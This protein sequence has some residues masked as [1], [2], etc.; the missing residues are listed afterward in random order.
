M[1]FTSS[2]T[3]TKQKKSSLNTP[4][5]AALKEGPVDW[6]PHDYQKKAMKFA[7]ERAVAALFLDPGLGKTSITLGVFK[8][9]KARKIIRR[10]LVIC[11]LRVAHAVWPGEVKKWKNFNG[12]SLSILHGKDKDRLR[13]DDADIHVIN[14]EGLEWLL[15]KHTKRSWPY[16]M[17]VVD[18]STFFKHTNRV[19]YQMLKDILD[20]FSRRYILTGT[21]VPNGLLDLYG[22]IYLL[23]HGRSLGPFFT[24][25]RAEHFVPYGYGWQI[26]EG[27]EKKIQD[28]IKHLAL[29]MDAKDFLDIKEPIINVIRVDL[30]AKARKLY[31]D[32]EN[33]LF[34]DLDS[35]RV[36][37]VN[38]AVSLMKCRQIA[39]GG[40]YTTPDLKKWETIHLAKVEAVKEIVDELNGG[41]ALISYEF[42][43]DLD[44]LR[45]AL[46]DPPSSR[47]LPANKM[48]KFEEEWRRE[49]HPIF[50]GQPASVS[51]GLNLQGGRAVVFHS[52][53]Y[54][55]EHYYQ[56]VRRVV[57][58]GNPHQVVI[59]LIV[60]RNTVDEA[61]LSVLRAKERTEASFVKALKR[62][63]L[64]RA[65]K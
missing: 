5:K 31:D 39:N 9:L 53:T 17:L 55:Y 11:P 15:S 25:Y 46:G 3:S 32:M 49:K 47:S 29:R 37:A 52:L 27:E 30:P 65:R 13:V 41:P 21:P 64:S 34:A 2:T 16:D 51:Y 22:Q 58:Q 8:I 1:P 40:L 28:K 4:F 61:M 62:Y 42:N 19:R 44:R 20:L 23:D 54:N 33:L 12:I 45:K 56:F 36:K 57:R 10:M 26:I 59:H 24:R 18:E 50:L 14:P 35:G 63:Q 43:H 7:L 60:A 38:A 48:M 6:V